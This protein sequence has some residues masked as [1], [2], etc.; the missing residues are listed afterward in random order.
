MWFPQGCVLFQ[1]YNY[2]FS[3]AVVA[4]S[5]AQRK[6]HPLVERCNAAEGHY[7]SALRVSLS[8]S[9]DCVAPL[10]KGAAIAREARLAV[11]D[12]KLT[13]LAIITLKEH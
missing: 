11:N 4:R 1:G 9:T 2:G 5:K 12:D 3:N 7:S 10:D 13:E 6:G 8:S